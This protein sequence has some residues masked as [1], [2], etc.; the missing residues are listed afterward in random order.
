MR[1]R[2]RL[3]L[4]IMSLPVHVFASQKQ[5]LLETILPKD[6]AQEHLNWIIEFIGHDRTQTYEKI[7]KYLNDNMNYLNQKSLLNLLI[8]VITFQKEKGF[9]RETEF[10]PIMEVAKI[11]KLE[12][13]LIQNL[14]RK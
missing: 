12:L 8:E 1:E 3:L 14:K 10:Y 7:L 5:K 11:W 6:K 4:I 9:M 13:R 2:F